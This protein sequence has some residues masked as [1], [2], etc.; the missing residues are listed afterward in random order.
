MRLSERVYLVG[1][2]LLGLGLTDDYDCHVYLIDGGT[3]LALVDAGSGRRP[4]LILEQVRAD[5]FDPAAIR[6]I[7]LT[8]GHA[9]HAG[10]AA[11][12]HKLT[13]AAVGA[14]AGAARAIA[15]GDEPALRLTEARRA[16]IYP[17][18]YRL[19]PCPVE[20]CLDDEQQ[21]RVGDL[22]LTT[23]DTPGHAAH[24]VSFILDH[25]KVR[26]LFAGDTV[27]AGGQIVLI[28]TPDCSLQAY[29]QTVLRLDALRAEALL[30]GHWTPVLSGG[31]RHIRSAA[32][33]Y[34]RLGVP[35]NA[36]DHLAL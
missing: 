11:A 36:L 19:A 31:W 26:F 1:S 4:E 35:R 33:A 16:G 12:L 32:D 3:E 9:D 18:E 15:A 23:L 10:G 7:L 25:G 29:R 2:G 14:P 6:T 17:E 8:H 27:M 24:H 21:V 28:G 20:I 22:V 34:R 13:G 5:G 30:P